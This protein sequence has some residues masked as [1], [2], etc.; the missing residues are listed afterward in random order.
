MVAIETDHLVYWQTMLYLENNI[1][2]LED[3]IMNLEGKHGN[4]IL[5]ICNSGSPTPAR[6]PALEMHSFS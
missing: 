5:V 4:V 2:T 3:N 1:F 6:S